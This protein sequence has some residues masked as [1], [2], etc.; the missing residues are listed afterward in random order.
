[1]GIVYFVILLS[2]IVVVHEVGHLIAAKIFN[3]YC[4]EFSLGMG[5]K[6][7]GKKIGETTYNIRLFLVGGFVA[8]AGDNENQLESKVSTEEIPKERTIPGIA[9]WKKIIIMLAGVLMNFILALVLVCGI[10]FSRGSYIASPAAIVGGIIA[11]SPASESSLKTG[12]IIKKVEFSNGTVVEN[13]ETFMEIL[14]YSSTNKDPM[15]YTVERDGMLLTTVL[16][17]KL[18]EET[19]Q[20]YVGIE[21]PSGKEIEISFANV[22]PVSFD[23]LWGTTGIIISSLL[24]LFRGI[25]LDNMSG[26]VG[27]YS[28]SS[29]AASQG[30]STYIFLIA[31]ISLNVGIFNLL[32]LPIL[33]GGRVI[34]TIY[35]MIFKKPIN[36]KV[37]NAI[38]SFSVFLI[39]L[40]MAFATFQDITKLF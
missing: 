27:I 3:V 36:K 8:M 29:Q 19:N 33:D 10:F 18:D 4:P 35:E 38:M 23:Y 31:L 40:L 9:N 12:D 15:T 16:T 25:G 5:P 34:M 30:L 39:L 26:P 24:N 22:I 1:M 20:Y 11:N 6:I 32:P 28:V 37:E 21:L 14:V 7:F 13:P 17:P 2:I